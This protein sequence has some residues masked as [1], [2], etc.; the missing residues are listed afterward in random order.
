VM[1]WDRFEMFCHLQNKAPP[2]KNAKG[3]KNCA[4]KS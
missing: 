1:L 2:A 3:N 4:C